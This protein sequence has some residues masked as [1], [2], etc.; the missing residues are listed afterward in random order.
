MVDNLG[1]VLA[2]LT[3][4][5]LVDQSAVLLALLKVE[6]LDVRTGYMMVAVMDNLSAAHLA[7]QKAALRVYYSADYLVHS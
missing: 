3:A 2:P 5:N 6:Q 7:L 1:T 4:V